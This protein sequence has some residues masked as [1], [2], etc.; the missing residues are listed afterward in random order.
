MQRKIASNG[1]NSIERKKAFS[2]IYINFTRTLTCSQKTSA[3]D[4]SRQN[5]H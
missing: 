2:C 5:F 4:K 3:K 1:E